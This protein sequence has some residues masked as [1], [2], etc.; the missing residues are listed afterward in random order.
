MSKTLRAKFS[1][2]HVI[3]YG[4][5]DKVNPNKKVNL[6]AVY[7]HNKNTEDNQFS[8]A[9]P[10]GSLEMMISNPNA[11]DFF[12]PG[13]KYYIDITEAPDDALNP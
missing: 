1:C 10:S 8:S 5:Y 7:S 11:T 2:A 3:D 6:T 13:K 9:T 4:S 12:Q